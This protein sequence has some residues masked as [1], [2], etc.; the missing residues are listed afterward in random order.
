[1]DFCFLTGATNI[2]KERPIAEEIIRE[3]AEIVKQLPP[4]Q[5]EFV[6]DETLKFDCRQRLQ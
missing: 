1:M 6:D 2:A 4:S 5:E 3:F